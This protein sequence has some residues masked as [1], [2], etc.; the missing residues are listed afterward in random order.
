M[1]SPDTLD[2]SLLAPCGMNCGVCYMHVAPKK[3]GK[4]CQGCLEDDTNKPRHCRKCKI[5]DCV[6]DKG[7]LHCYQCD[8]L[9]CKLLKNLDKSYRKRY[10]TSLVENC[11]YVREHGISRFMAQEREKWTC[12][13]CGGLF[14]LHDGTCS[15]CQS[16]F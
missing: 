10:Q 12:A 11:L 8:N 7:I 3:Y 5:R 4:A 13:K 14:S 6:S 16:G 9:P 2:D 1:K 15:E